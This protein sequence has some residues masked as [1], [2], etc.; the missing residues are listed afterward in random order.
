MLS[1]PLSPRQNHLLAALPAVDYERVLPSLELISLSLGWAAYEAGRKQS[2]VYFPTDS[3]ISMVYV[4]TTGF[5]TEIAVTGN[6]GLVGIPLLMGDEATPSR[7]VVRSAGS[8]YRL[9]AAEL[10]KE[11]ELGGALKPLL[12]LYTQSLMTQIALNVACNRHHSVDQR[13]CRWILMSLDRAPSGQLKT[14]HEQIASMLG[15]RREGI[16]EA[17]GRLQRDKLIQCS[18]GNIAALDR[19]GLEARACECYAV[20]RHEADRLLPPAQ[21]GQ[22]IFRKPLQFSGSQKYVRSR[23]DLRR[24]A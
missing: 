5:S 21:S 14:T 23:T 9:T 19:G 13:L 8:A 20:V 7:A 18:R 10:K 6:D 17:T 24:T 11:F 1:L 2:H 4:T 12:L 22:S 15:V 16:T 3:I